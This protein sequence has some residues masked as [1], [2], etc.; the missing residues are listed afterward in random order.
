MAK[1]GYSTEFMEF[2]RI[3]PCRWICS[4]DRY[5]KIG[6]DKAWI[7]WKRMSDKDKRWAMFSSHKERVSEFMP[8]PWR[9]LR[10]KK[11]KDWDY[12]ASNPIPLKPPTMRQDAK[13]SPRPMETIPRFKKDVEMTTRDKAQ[14]QIKKLAEKMKA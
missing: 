12:E 14:E 11:Y 9:W 8:D 6:K 10:D 3:I 5:V 1:D 13:S 7:V 2:W 4:S